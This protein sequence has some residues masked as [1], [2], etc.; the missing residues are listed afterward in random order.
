MKLD[1]HFS[2]LQHANIMRINQT[3]FDDYFL[4]FAI[5]VDFTPG[6]YLPLLVQPTASDIDRAMTRNMSDIITILFCNKINLTIDNDPIFEWDTYSVDACQLPAPN[7]YNRT[8]QATYY[9]PQ[10]RLTDIGAEY[11]KHIV[12]NRR[13][14]EIKKLSDE[15]T[16]MQ[17]SIDNTHKL[18]F[19]SKWK[20]IKSIIA[21]AG[22][23][24]AVIT[25]IWASIDQDSLKTMAAPVIQLF[26]N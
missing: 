24:L 16:E 18:A 23:S 5:S 20:L 1:R 17:H 12:N 22:A 11:A 14:A 10:I 25:A 7:I 15:C 9:Y 2:E 3:M 8:S 21:S 13:I 19:I 4:Q 26:K 6:I